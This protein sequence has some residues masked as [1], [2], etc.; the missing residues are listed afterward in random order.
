MNI[1]DAKR[2]VAR[3]EKHP[4]GIFKVKKN[5]LVRIS[6]FNFPARF[7]R[8]IEDRDGAVTNK[9]T[10]LMKK[11]K[12]VVTA[13]AHEKKIVIT[14]IKDSTAESVNVLSQPIINEASQQLIEKNVP[15]YFHDNHLIKGE[16]Y[17][18]KMHNNNISEL[19]QLKKNKSEFIDVLNYLQRNRLIAPAHYGSM[20]EK[21]DMS[22]LPDLKLL[23][24]NHLEV[25]RKERH[26]AKALKNQQTLQEVKE[27]YKISGEVTSNPETFLIHEIDVHLKP[28]FTQQITESTE[29]TSRPPLIE[30]LYPNFQAKFPTSQMTKK[31]LE[32]FALDAYIDACSIHINQLAAVSKH[33]KTKDLR[34]IFQHPIAIDF[35]GLNPDIVNKK[36][37]T[38]IAKMKNVRSGV[39]NQKILNRF[40]E[41]SA[42]QELIKKSVS[43]KNDIPLMTLLQSEAPKSLSQEILQEATLKAYLPIYQRWIRR[44]IK[45]GDRA[46][47]VELALKKQLIKD[48]PGLDKKI[49]K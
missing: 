26:E 20:L 7:I 9:V 13:A 29:N 14:P 34:S 21:N 33:L 39:K 4:E 40:M 45:T 35:K 22:Q 24:E 10:A 19:N 6:S 46:K 15:E 5:E 27:K 17:D 31:D 43:Q 37:D 49:I 38:A 42:T 47:N 2:N 41:M 16:D 8:W 48:F 30:Q 18:S 36:I 25:K 32:I 3:A 12:E 44:K 1:N 28:Y 23:K 11:S